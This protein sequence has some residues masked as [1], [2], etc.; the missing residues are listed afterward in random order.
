MKWHKINWFKVIFFTS[1]T[2]TFLFMLG[3]IWLNDPDVSYN[4]GCTAFLF[5]TIGLISIPFLIV[6]ECC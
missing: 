5:G 3:S 2:L 6:L 4:C 1:F